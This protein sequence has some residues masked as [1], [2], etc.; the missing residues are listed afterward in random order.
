MHE[1]GHEQ[2]RRHVYC[3]GEEGGPD[4]NYPNNTG[5]IDVW[6]M[7]VI[8]D[9]LSIHHP[10]DHD[11]MTYCSDTW[12]SQWGW[13]LVAPW[14]AIISQ[15]DFD[16]APAPEDKTKVLRAYIPEDGEADWW[17]A[18]EYFA[19]DEIDGDV[20]PAQPIEFWAGDELLDSRDALVLGVE[21]TQDLMV[22]VDIEGIDW[23]AV[24]R[25]ERPSEDLAMPVQKADIEI[26]VADEI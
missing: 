9:V 24:T 17:T 2:G 4:P 1:I 26:I 11:Y 10:L 21:H 16:G 6:G 13:N 20:H 22:A 7:D 12:V 18:D 19:A 5:D 25:I 14:I 15:W 3:N 23:D 8:S